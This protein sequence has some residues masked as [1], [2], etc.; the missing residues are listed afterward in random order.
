[1]GLEQRSDE[2]GSVCRMTRERA[3]RMTLA[4]ALRRVRGARG[5]TQRALAAKAGV[6]EKY[7]SRIERGLATPS[8]LVVH[9]LAQALG[10]DLDELVATRIVQPLPLVAALTRLLERR[11]PAELERAERVLAALLR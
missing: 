5:L 7:L 11:S 1:L 2:P 10:V 8:I 3:L 4:R 9:R 6:G